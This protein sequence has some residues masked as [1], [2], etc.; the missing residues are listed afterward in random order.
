MHEVDRRPSRVSHP[1]AKE[2]VNLWSMDQVVVHNR[3]LKSIQ[4][5][6]S[7][8][9]IFLENELRQERQWAQP[10]DPLTRLPK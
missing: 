4:P 10:F 7:G 6:P 9:S 2:K 3:R 1:C 8:S 5:T